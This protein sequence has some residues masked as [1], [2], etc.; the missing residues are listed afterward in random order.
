MKTSLATIPT[1]APMAA[2]VPDDADV[3]AAAEEAT[4]AGLHL[5]CNG[6]RSC[7]SPIVPPG[8]FKIA[9]RIKPATTTTSQEAT[10]CHA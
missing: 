7:I 2:I 10:L 5:I 9:V 4:A 6:R 3:F 8:W 1:A